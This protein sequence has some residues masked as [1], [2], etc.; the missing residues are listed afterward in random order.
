MTNSFKH[1]KINLLFLEND[2]NQKEKLEAQINNIPGI[3][4]NLKYDV[5]KSDSETIIEK[6]FL[7]KESNTPSFFFID[8]YGHPFPFQLMRKI[9]KKPL[10]EI[11]VNFMFSHIIRDIPNLSEKERCL[12]LFYPDDPNNLDLKTKDKFDKEKILGY[13]HNRIGAKYYIP[14]SVNF[15]PDE[16]ISSSRV[17]YFL[18]HY[19]NSFKAFK[20]MLDVM[21][22]H[23]DRDKPLTVSDKQYILFQEKS[24]DDLEKLILDKYN[25]TGKKLTFDSFV[26]V[27]WSWYFR[28][29]HFRN[30]LK[31]LE[32]ERAIDIDR[33]SSKTSGL[34][35]EDIIK[36]KRF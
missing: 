14:F 13:L 10:T 4:P 11:M 6:E 36:F 24:L 2:D 23:S 35:E 18:I 12:K 20:L 32:K 21:W 34:K 15:G 1:K 30:V 31:K 29:T 8:P 33:V 28:E 25:G 5:K 16:K 26:E 17:K 7:Q 9:M 19:S 3:P 22:A 27:N